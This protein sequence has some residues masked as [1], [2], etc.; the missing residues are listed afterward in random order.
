MTSQLEDELTHTLAGAAD[1][2][3]E[4]DESFV[5]GVHRRR[6]ARTH[7]R[8][9]MVAGC[10][11]VLAVVSG[12]AVTNL[13]WR[14][15]EPG[16][17]FASSDWSGTV[18]DFATADPPDK[19]WPDAVHRLPATLPNGAKYQV[20]AV[21]GGDRYLVR[22]TAGVPSASAPWVYNAR[23]GDLVF[24]GT[25]EMRT[26]P[27]SSSK[28][29]TTAVGDYAVWFG[30]AS[31][32]NQRDAGVWTARLDGTGDPKMIA[33]VKDHGSIP[34]L[35]GVLGDS[36]YWAQEGSG[37]YRLPVSGGTPQ[38]VRDSDG[39]QL[40]GLSPWV[41]TTGH[42]VAEEDPTPDKGVLWDLETGERRP[43][44]SHKDAQTVICAPQICTG[45]TERGTYF[46][47][48]L[49][50]TGFQ[51]LPYPEDGFHATPAIGG[52]FS[53]GTVKTSDGTFRYIWDIVGDKVASAAAPAG[54]DDGTAY[55]FE[56]STFQ[57][58]AGDG[59]VRVLDL[60][61]IR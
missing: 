52:R 18:P 29:W 31:E 4:P 43:W 56:S 39:Y 55:G 22:T 30:T 2:A 20:F 42:L 11:A 14:A 51:E 57:W 5:E 54:Q 12:V 41:D 44:V 6:R 25:E 7:R 13:S 37:T 15:T 28:D 33:T 59:S 49:D 34:P 58:L 50:G 19:V 46:V 36:V 61:A 38:R 53:I 24:L 47:Q 45:R 35:I 3:P 10:A 40:F 48:R 23:T 16:P 21:L 9:A 8:V 17:P 27:G 26:R 60:K 32:S 1:L